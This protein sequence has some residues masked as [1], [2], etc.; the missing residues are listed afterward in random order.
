[1]DHKAEEAIKAIIEHEFK[2]HTVMCITHRLDTII[3]FDRVIVMEKGC[4]V[5]IGNP[6]NLLASNSKFKALW[7]ARPRSVA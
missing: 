6:K 4:V 7:S 1:V 5:E 2:D 3:G